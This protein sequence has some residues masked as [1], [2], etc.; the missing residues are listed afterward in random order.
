MYLP[1]HEELYITSDLLQSTNS[2]SLPII[3][4]S[5]IKLHRRR[6]QDSGRE[7]SDDGRDDDD[8]ITSVEWAKLRPPQSMAMPASGIPYSQGMVFCSQGNLTEGTGGLYYMPHNKPPVPLVTGFY[9]KDF[10][11]PYDVV[12]T[13]SDGALWFTDPRHGHE[14]DFRKRP[15][16]PCHVYRFHPATDDLRVVVDGLGRPTGIA[17]SPDGSTAYITDTDACRADGTQDESR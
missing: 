6:R 11:S 2:G 3:L 15:S 16:L 10:N 5:R 14:K 4:I 7:R 13:K 17:F 12:L 1:Q 8:A 9:G